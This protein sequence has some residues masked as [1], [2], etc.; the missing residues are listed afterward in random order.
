MRAVHVKMFI[1]KL[2]I[3]QIKTAFDSLDLTM[4]I[5]YHG[6]EPCYLHESLTLRSSVS[7]RSTLAFSNEDFLMPQV[8]TWQADIFH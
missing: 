6:N 3:F 4:Y 8:R 1:K 2:Q 7:V 5:T